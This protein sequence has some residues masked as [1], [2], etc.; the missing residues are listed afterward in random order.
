MNNHEFQKP[1][2]FNNDMKRRFDDQTEFAK[3]FDNPAFDIRSSLDN[4][5]NIDEEILN[6]RKLKNKK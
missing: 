6:K 5:Y 2:P 1:N 3:E 4:S